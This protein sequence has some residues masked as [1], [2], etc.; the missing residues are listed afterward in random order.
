[1]ADEPRNWA[2]RWRRK[3]QH[4]SLDEWVYGDGNT[5]HSTGHLD[6]GVNAD[7]EVVAVWYRCMLLPFKQY[8]AD[9]SPSVGRGNPGT[10]RISGVVLTEQ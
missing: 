1:V 10:H 2:A 8:D 4:R 3:P 7:G 6:V 5:I 9:G